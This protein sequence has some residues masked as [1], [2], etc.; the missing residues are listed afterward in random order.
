MAASPT[1]SR[2]T[3]A[4]IA[5][6]RTFA[7]VVPP[8]G[9]LPNGAVVPASD[10]LPASAPASAGPPASASGVPPF[11]PFG[12]VVLLLQPQSHPKRIPANKTARMPP[13][14]GDGK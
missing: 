8:S 9:E 13:P 14:Q 3:A 5:G 6:T 12:G 11:P 2:S 1:V 7:A 4:G 10:V